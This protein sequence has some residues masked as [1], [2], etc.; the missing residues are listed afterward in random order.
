MLRKWFGYGVAMVMLSLSLLAPA[1]V[2]KDLA[3]AVVPVADRSAAS[4]KQVLPQT[5]GDALVKISGNATVMTVPAIQTALAD[6]NRYV[7]SYRFAPNPDTQNTTQPWLVYIQFDQHGLEKLLK[8][9]GQAIWGANRPQTLL[10]LSVPQ[11]D[12]VSVLASGDTTALGQIVQ[13][14]ADARGMPF[15]LPTMDLQDEANAPSDISQLPNDVQMQNEAARYGVESILAVSITA[16][17]SN[18]LNA[19]WKL[20]V[21]G[22]PY[23]WQKSGNDVSA[24]LSSGLNTA[25]DMLANRFATLKSSGLRSNVMMEVGNVVDLSQYSQVLALLKKLSAVAGVKVVDMSQNTLLLQVS[26]TGGSA[27][28]AN[29]LQTV[30]ELKSQTPAT[31]AAQPAD[32]YYQLED[33]NANPAH[34]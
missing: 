30:A 24:L 8:D 21:D 28:L 27:V 14:T 16:G 6:A 19:Q 23:M 32:L 4:L 10:W 1:E 12:Q 2:V 31:N 11:S 34:A 15:M 17:D 33:Q 20:L 7:V 3:S 18:T 5:I 9:N 13:Q 22:T 26:V 25:A 29:A